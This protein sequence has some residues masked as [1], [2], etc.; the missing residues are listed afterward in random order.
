MSVSRMQRDTR[1]LKFYPYMGKMDQ[2]K[3]LVLIYFTKSP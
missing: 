2:R 1:Y 3:S